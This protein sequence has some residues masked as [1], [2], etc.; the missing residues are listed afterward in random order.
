[1]K[2]VS[3][4]THTQEQL[5]AWANQNNPNNKAYQANLDH[6]SNQLNPNHKTHQ[7]RHN[8]QRKYQESGY[9]EWAPDYPEWDD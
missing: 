3:G 7:Q 8:A 9:V 6:H 4:K 5:N 1:M 2:K